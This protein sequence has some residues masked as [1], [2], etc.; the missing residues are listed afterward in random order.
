MSISQSNSPRP[1]PI[2][3]VQFLRVLRTRFGVHFEVRDES[4]VMERDEKRVTIS[5]S[6]DG[7]DMVYGRAVREVLM[8]L[9]INESAYSEALETAEAAAKG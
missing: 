9:G 6:V 1:G 8:R 2:H 5:K 4:Y 3:R 7:S